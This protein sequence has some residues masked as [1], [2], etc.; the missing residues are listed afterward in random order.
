MVSRRVILPGKWVGYGTMLDEC[1]GCPY[2]LMCMMHPPEE[3]QHATLVRCGKRGGH[4]VVHYL[5][6]FPCEPE[7]NVPCSLVLRMQFMTAPI[8]PCVDCEILKKNDEKRL[9]A[10]T[11]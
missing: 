7:E 1:S 10:F 3:L 2:S 8:A 11:E 5:G 4:A 9:K 6:Q